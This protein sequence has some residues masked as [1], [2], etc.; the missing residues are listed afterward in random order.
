MRLLPFLCLL[1]Q[2]GSSQ[3]MPVYRPRPVPSGVIRVLGN[4]HMDKL[5]EIWE[6]GFRTH[7]PGVR[8]ENTYLGTA[9]AIAG[10]YLK[11]ADLALMGREVMPMEDIAY[12]RVFPNS[13]FEIAV[14]TASFNVPLET[15]AFAIFVNAR[16]P[17]EKL[18]LRQLDA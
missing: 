18:T 12:R 2:L 6:E 11:T 4:S 17:I 13:P 5:M 15:F 8:F 1:E 14:A 3:E 7:Q 9:N 10:L 16:N